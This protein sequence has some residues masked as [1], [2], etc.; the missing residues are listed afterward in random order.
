M[1]IAYY[2]FIPI[3]LFIS[4]FAKAVNGVNADST[5]NWWIAP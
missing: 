5:V 3:L 2:I 1:I 4:G